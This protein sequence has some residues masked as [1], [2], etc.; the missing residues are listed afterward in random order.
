MHAAVAA[1]FD[2][3]STP[4]KGRWSYRGGTRPAESDGLL[5]PPKIGSHVLTT[6][7]DTSR[8]GMLLYKSDCHLVLR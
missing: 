8:Q 7:P 3:H 6:F 1:V 4:G 5:T 2:V